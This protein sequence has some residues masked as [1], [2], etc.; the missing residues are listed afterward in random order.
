MEVFR[1]LLMGFHL[2]TLFLSANDF[3]RKKPLRNVK[4]EA[5][6]FANLETVNLFKTLMRNCK[7][8]YI[9]IQ[10]DFKKAKKNPLNFHSILRHTFSI[11]HLSNS[12][13]C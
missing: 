12:H 2:L 11:F 1:V 9:L 10:N 13:F 6:L 7:K 5:F 4:S 8:I 3:Q